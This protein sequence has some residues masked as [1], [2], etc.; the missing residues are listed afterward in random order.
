M[1]DWN[2]MA[3]ETLDAALTREHREI[4][5]GLEAFA[6]SLAEGEARV[7]PLLGAVEALRRHIYLEEEMLFPALRAAGLIAPVLVMLREHGA[8][9]QAMDT[10]TA[11]AEGGADQ[12]AMRRVGRELASLLETHNMKEEPI[13][14]TQADRVLSAP[15]SEELGAF[16]ESGRMPEGWVATAARG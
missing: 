14:Y 10:L 2:S 13:L 16:L 9:W 11:E 6:A 12:E 8:I 3:N 7:E 1:E 5:A 15:A 4:D